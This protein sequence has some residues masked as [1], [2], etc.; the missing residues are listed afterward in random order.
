MDKVK[1]ATKTISDK[2]DDAHITVEEKTLKY[3]EVVK[4]DHHRMAERNGA[5]TPPAIVSI[6]ADDSRI[7]SE[8][9]SINQLIGI[10]MPF[11]ILAYTEPNS[12]K[13]SYAYTSAE[14]IRRRHDLKQHDLTD[15]KKVIDDIVAQLPPDAI[16]STDYLTVN[17]GFG[18]IKI[19]SDYKFY[20][21]LTKIR[22]FVH[23][24]QTNR[25]FS[26]IDFQKDAM[27]YDISVGPTM[28]CL[29]GVP[30]V[31]AEAMYDATKIGLEAFCQKVLVYEDTDGF[32]YVAFNDA[33]KFG[34]LYYGKTNKGQINV[35][36]Q[37]TVGLTN[38]VTNPEKYKK[39]EANIVEIDNC[40]PKPFTI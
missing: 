33:T 20:L 10:D 32:V 11:K 8:L 29:F 27:E 17:N 23:D 21:T 30:E 38:T 3:R 1:A 14:F 4:L 16:S 2:V 36:T 6:F 18:I 5:E 15:Y 25:W 39:Q 24:N 31:G 7:V 28:L 19:K 37:M 12:Q 26:Q 13:A 40:L 9:L 35:K 22:E 34:E